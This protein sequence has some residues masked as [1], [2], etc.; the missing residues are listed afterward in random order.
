MDWSGVVWVAAVVE[1]SYLKAV[2]AAD[3]TWAAR[4]EV[5]VAVHR[6]ERWESAV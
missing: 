4:M 6:Q 2:V 1:V 5:A 3:R